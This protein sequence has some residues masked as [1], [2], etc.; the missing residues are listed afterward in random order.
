MRK[1]LT[2][3]ITRLIWLYQ[4]MFSG[5]L[6]SRCRFYPSCSQ[7]GIE[8]IE[9]HGPL[10]GGFLAVKRLCK[11]HPYHPGGID[12]VPVLPGGSLAEPTGEHE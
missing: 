12:N 1:A 9:I 10:S 5:F 8:A 4:A 2:K 11:C 3:V 6:G 7:Y